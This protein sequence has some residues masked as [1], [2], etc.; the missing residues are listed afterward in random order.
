MDVADGKISGT[1]SYLE[2]GDIAGYWGPGNF[3]V[4]KFTNIDADATS[5]LVGMEP[6]MGS[7]LQELINDPDKNSVFKVTNKDTQRFKVIQKTGSYA[8][9]QYFDLSELV[10]LES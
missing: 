6:S 4:L 3:M 1:L 7:G 2:D 10:C 8:K 5:V 9:T